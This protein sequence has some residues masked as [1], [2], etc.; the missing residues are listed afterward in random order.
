M[1]DILFTVKRQRTESLIW[2]TCFLLA[3]LTNV[4]SIIVYNTEWKEL[5]TQFFWVLA[6]S[7]FIYFVVLA[8]RLLYWVIR[9]RI[10]EGK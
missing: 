5:Y 3:F 10:R 6:I 8:F 7:V 1:R 2:G 9:K 4:V